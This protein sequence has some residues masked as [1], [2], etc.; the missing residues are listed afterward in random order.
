MTVCVN[1]V[2]SLKFFVVAAVMC[3]NVAVAQ[4]QSVTEIETMY[5]GADNHVTLHIPGRLADRLVA[6]PASAEHPNTSANSDADEDTSSS[7]AISSSSSQGA[8]TG[9]YRVQV[10]LDNNARTAKNEARTRARNI[11]EQFPHY[12]TYV[13]YSSPYWR[14]RVG[15]F[16]TRDDADAAAAELSA[17]FPA[18]AREIRVVRDRIVVSSD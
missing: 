7:S 14:L 16:R 9:G 15:N 1:P 4:T 13:V 18:Y 11:S 6:V 10:F 2:L 3:Q 12:P 8:K 5:L 17:A